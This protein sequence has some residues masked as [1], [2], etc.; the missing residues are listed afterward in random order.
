MLS[1]YNTENLEDGLK[2]AWLAMSKAIL[3]YFHCARAEMVGY[4]MD[5]GQ[6]SSNWRRGVVVA[7]L[8]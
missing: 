8:V 1:L 7:S 3:S 6:F 4:V 5:R 2:F